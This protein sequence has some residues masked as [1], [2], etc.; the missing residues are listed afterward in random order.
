[1]CSCET[2]RDQRITRGGGRPGRKGPKSAP[3]DHPCDVREH[4]E[5]IQLPVYISSP[6]KSTHTAHNVTH[7]S[8]GKQYV[9]VCRIKDT[10]IHAQKHIPDI[11]SQRL[12]PRGWSRLEQ[13]KLCK[14]GNQR[15]S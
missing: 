3:V 9:F 12:R 14:H 15:P 1:M 5:L 11:H 7:A 2:P 6:G 4:T 8:T 13:R 10:C